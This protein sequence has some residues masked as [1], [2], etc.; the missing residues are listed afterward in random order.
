M[1]GPTLLQAIDLTP[2]AFA[3]FGE[4]KKSREER[5]SARGGCAVF[6][7]SNLLIFSFP[8]SLARQ[9]IL[10]TADGT[11]YGAPH[12]AS[13]ALPMANEGQKG[14]EKNKNALSEVPRLYIMSL[15][16]R[17]SLSF[18]R[19]TYHARVSQ[20]LASLDGAW[21]PWYLAVAAPTGS[22]EVRG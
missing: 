1:A 5:E 20:C 14:E 21:A 18:D 3:P 22:V 16:A 10:P 2:E 6:S 7:R 8:L 11:P 17:P 4:V 15:P 13:L 19:I 9:V 12:D